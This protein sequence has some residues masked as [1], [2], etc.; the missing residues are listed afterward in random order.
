MAPSAA[1]ADLTLCGR[2]TPLERSR[3]GFALRLGI[4][5][6][7]VGEVRVRFPDARVVSC[8]I[9]YVTPHLPVRFRL[10]ADASGC[11]VRM[12]RTA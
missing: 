6:E 4:A 7:G 10:E 2:T 9:G 1:S 12:D 11:A 8:P 3:D 5:C